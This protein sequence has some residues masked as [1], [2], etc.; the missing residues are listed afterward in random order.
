[1]VAF[2][3]SLPSIHY[4]YSFR[5]S[6]KYDICRKLANTEEFN[7]H[8]TIHKQ[9]CLSFQEAVRFQNLFDIFSENA[10]PPTKI[11]LL[12]KLYPKNVL[13]CIADVKGTVCY[14]NHTFAKN[15]FKNRF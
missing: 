4:S 13:K 9:K 7:Y 11:E 10:S 3:W 15:I 2:I 12:Q 14:L 8:Q 1:M 5:S 6:T